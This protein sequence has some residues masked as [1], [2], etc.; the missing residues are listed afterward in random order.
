MQSCLAY[1]DAASIMG[2]MTIN[3]ECDWPKSTLHLQSRVR[4]IHQFFNYNSDKLVLRLF[5]IAW[6]RPSLDCICKIPCFLALDEFDLNNVHKL[7]SN[8]K[9]SQPR[10]EPRAAGCKGMLSIVLRPPPHSG[11]KKEILC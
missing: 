5:C 7:S 6:L 2:L 1:F 10:F 4:M 3:Q 9:I 8:E 11:Q